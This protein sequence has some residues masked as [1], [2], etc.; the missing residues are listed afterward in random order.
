MMRQL[1][2][3]HFGMQN[4]QKVGYP[5]ALMLP[6]RLPQVSMMQLSDWTDVV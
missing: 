6:P 4:A 2:L 3:E 5:R 1:L